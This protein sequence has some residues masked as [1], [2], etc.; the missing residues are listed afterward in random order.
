MNPD[1]LA[2]L[3]S[4][5]FPLPKVYSLESVEKEGEPSLEQLI[6]ACSDL[7]SYVTHEKRP[8]MLREWRA[9]AKIAIFPTFGTTAKEA[10][11]NLYIALSDAGRID[12]VKRYHTDGGS[13]ALTLAKESS[14]AEPPVLHKEME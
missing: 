10:V 5:G 13:S 1:L 3:K 11:G 12:I 9:A 6:E 2:K 14:L 8:D 7:F 4:S